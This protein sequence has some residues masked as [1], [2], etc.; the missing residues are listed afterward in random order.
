[1]A[2]PFPAL[3]RSRGRPSP[4]HRTRGKGSALP[5]HPRLR[6]GYPTERGGPPPLLGL[7]PGLCGRRRTVTY[8][9]HRTVSQLFW[10]RLPAGSPTH[11]FPRSD[12][13]A[14]L[15]STPILNATVQAPAASQPADAVWNVPV[16]PSKSENPPKREDKKVIPL[17][18]VRPSFC[19]NSVPYYPSTKGLDIYRKE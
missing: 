4:L 17:R 14:A 18:Q 9:T 5:T 15:L 2:T 3:L 11:H 12:S 19:V 6:R 7:S 16:F 8:F 13:H 1:M 10:V